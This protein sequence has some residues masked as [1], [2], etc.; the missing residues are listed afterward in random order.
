MLSSIKTISILRLLQRL[1]DDVDDVDDDDD[2]DGDEEAAASALM[3]EHYVFT[4]EK[5]RSSFQ[6][7]YSYVLNRLALFVNED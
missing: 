3:P 6:T 4:P 1:E 2:D 7:F 5:G